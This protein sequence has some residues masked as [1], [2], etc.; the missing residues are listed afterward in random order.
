MAGCAAGAPCQQQALS[1]SKMPS[2]DG[3][4]AAE[5]DQKLAIGS[6]RSTATCSALGLTAPTH[7][8]TQRVEASPSVS[9]VTSPEPPH[10]P[11]QQRRREQQQQTLRSSVT[12]ESD[13]IPGI[14]LLA[15]GIQKSPR[16]LRRDKL[17]RFPSVSDLVLFAGA[18]QADSDT[19]LQST[20]STCSRVYT[21]Q[22]A[23]ALG[24]RRTQSCHSQMTSHDR[25]PTEGQECP[26]QRFNAWKAQHPDASRAEAKAFVERDLC[27]YTSRR[28]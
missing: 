8:T 25:Q 20:S 14:R 22:P 21:H 19:G 1:T 9:R 4:L 15:R 10:H 3:L 5:F 7:D 26:W 12:H 18:A 13:G 27:E 17:G 2:H 11:K 16:R 23:A 28:L 6:T 24:M